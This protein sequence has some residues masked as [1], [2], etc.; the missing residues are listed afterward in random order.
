MV[1]MTF[2]STMT[3][4]TSL[5]LAVL[6]SLLLGSLSVSAQSTSCGCV[7]VNVTLD[8]NCQF[9]LSTASV[10]TGNNCGYTKVIVQDGNPAN[11][12]TVDCAGLFTY[13]LFAT[14]QTGTTTGAL[15]CWGK[16]LA[17]DKT[18]P[19]ISIYDAY[20]SYLCTEVNAVL[21]NPKTVGAS[22][23]GNGKVGYATAADNC[24]GKCSCEQPT[25]ANGRLKFSDRVVY[26]PCAGSDF[27]ASFVRVD[28]FMLLNFIR[29][30]FLASFCDIISD[31]F[32]HCEEFQ[33]LFNIRN[34][35]SKQFILHLLLLV[36]SAFTVSKNFI[37]NQLS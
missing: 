34:N 25:L 15:I 16:V 11:G 5:C 31:N 17:E 6:A 10:A 23:N 18:P 2:T 35:H 8:A 7:Q 36:Q 21:N 29:F 22:A 1:K 37:S 20:C 24:G 30:T 33:I 12:A 19:V 4:M 9:T 13:G 27:G 26:Y 28:I 3:K 32:G 14:D